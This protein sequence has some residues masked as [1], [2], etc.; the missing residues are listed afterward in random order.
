M[1]ATVDC[2]VKDALLDRPR[3]RHQSVNVRFVQFGRQVFHK[4]TYLVIHSLMKT[5]LPIELDII[6]TGPEIERLTALVAQFGLSA[7]VRFL[8]WY[9]SHADLLDSLDQYR[10]FVLPSIEDANGIVV[11]ESMALGL[12]PV[13]L[14]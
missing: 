10:G 2:G 3:V 13:C 5:R 9:P 4:C 12:P 14:D 6:G 8:G 11:Q 7:R 1:V